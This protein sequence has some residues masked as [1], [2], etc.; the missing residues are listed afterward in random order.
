MSGRCVYCRQDVGVVLF[1]FDGVSAEPV[2]ACRD[3][4]D[5]LHLAVFKVDVLDATTLPAHPVC[6]DC[7]RSLPSPDTEPAVVWVCDRVRGIVASCNACRV[8]SG[9]STL[10]TIVPPEGHAPDPLAE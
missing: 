3:C 1:V 8:T 4:R 10:V 5:R 2:P 7:G 6:E 9:R